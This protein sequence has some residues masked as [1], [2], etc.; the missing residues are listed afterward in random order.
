[1]I[2]NFDVLFR[3]L[4]LF[5]LR[6]PLYY[7]Y[8][9]GP[10]WIGFWEGQSPAGICSTLTAVHDMHWV[11]LGVSECEMLIERKF[12]AFAIV[13]Y[14]IL[15]ILFVGCVTSH[16]YIGCLLLWFRRCFAWGQNKTKTNKRKKIVMS[17]H[18]DQAK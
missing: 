16:C 7:L 2:V 12:E 6:R 8:L 3:F 13:V 1:M 17:Q 4:F 15:I 18:S 14:T 11:M 9:N 10:A 5:L